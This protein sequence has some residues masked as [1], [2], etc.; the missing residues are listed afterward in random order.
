MEELEDLVNETVA[1]VAA[2]LDLDGEFARF[3]SQL[4]RLERKKYEVTQIF[5]EC[6]ELLKNIKSD[7]DAEDVAE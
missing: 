3:S 7:M 5:A 4:K 2:D 1:K 6:E